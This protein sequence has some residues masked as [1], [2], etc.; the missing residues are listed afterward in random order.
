M[1]ETLRASADV[2]GV[3]MCI[4]GI[5]IEG[6]NLAVYFDDGSVER[7]ELDMMSRESVLSLARQN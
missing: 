1:R 5:E 3:G 7:V 6:A 2:V 4:V